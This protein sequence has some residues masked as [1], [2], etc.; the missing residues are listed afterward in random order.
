MSG[1]VDA[2]AGM[3]S[4]W[5]YVVIAALAVAESAALV[6][7]VVPG[8]AAL[9]VGGFAASQGRVSLPVLAVVATVAAI[10]GDSIGYELGRHFG[11]RVRVT[12]VGLWVGEERWSRADQF[13]ERRGG[14]AVLIGRWVGLL[15]ALVPGVA[16][17]TR[18]PY[19]RF[20]L[21]NVLGAVVW[22]P[23]VIAA[24]YF[25]GGSFRSVERWLGRASL[26]VAVIAVF[27]FGL[28]L[29]ARWVIAHRQRVVDAASRVRG[30]SAVR[31]MASP[32][33]DRRRV[34]SCQLA[35]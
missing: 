27:G 6:G 25:A 2:L 20:L 35:P 12:R 21:W 33:A 17:T 24:G 29:G 28:W 31:R 15:R 13:I 7:L 10:V 30:L 14:P 18:M 26:V 1:L 3:A 4:P 8:E 23:T 34:G 9:L 22:A 11:P 5:L 32:R 16:G 19:G